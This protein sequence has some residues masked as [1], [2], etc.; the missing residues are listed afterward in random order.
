LLCICSELLDLTALL[1]IIVAITG[2]VYSTN[3]I[4]SDNSSSGAAILQASEEQHIMKQKSDGDWKHEKTVIFES[5]REVPWS[6]DDGSGVLV[7]ILNGK[8]ANNLTLE[9]L[10]DEYLPVGK[11]FLRYAIDQYSGIRLLGVRRTERALPVGTT[12]TAIGELS[13]GV[14][15]PGSGTSGPRCLVLQKPTDAALPFYVSERALP[16]LIEG[17]SSLSSACKCGAYVF[18][19]LGVYLLVSRAVSDFA[20]NIRRK[21]YRAR[22]LQQA[23]QQRL[24]AANST[25]NSEGAIADPDVNR[26]TCVICLENA[27]DCVFVRCGH[28]CCCMGCASRLR[29]CPICRKTTTVMKVYMS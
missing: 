17:L 10:L 12:V 15:R 20:A 26:S 2:H 24:A 19:A 27:L 1:P 7:E 29:Q 16:E 9:T 4:K 28:L 18:G 5:I 14:P 13:T 8:H 3:P 22:M 11:G 23:K 6:L 25:E 21:R